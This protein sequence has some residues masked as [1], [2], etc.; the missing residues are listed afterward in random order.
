MLIIFAVLINKEMD[1]KQIQEQRM[2]GYFIQ[3]TKEILKAEGLKSISVRNIA[4]RAG[5]S[6]ATLYNYFKD[7][8]DLIFL[9]V[10]DFQGEIETSITEKITGIVP[11]K[12]RM[13]IISMEY[14]NYFLEYPGIFELFYLER[15][16]DISSNT[17]ATQLIVNF[18]DRLCD[19]DWKAIEPDKNA[20]KLRKSEL[21]YT[22]T[23]LLLFYLNRREPASYQEFIDRA[24]NQLSFIID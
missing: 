15:M 4:D 23:G 5:Y 2:K 10:K 16:S 12:E 18:L 21:N 6:Y 14:L 19:E 8:K 7:V 13:K 22:I 3:A 24:N 9:C 17:E 1:N 11:G 20:R